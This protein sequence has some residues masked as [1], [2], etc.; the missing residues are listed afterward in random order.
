MKLSEV[1]VFLTTVFHGCKLVVILVNEM[2]TSRGCSDPSRLS[3][4]SDSPENENALL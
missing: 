3:S 2:P 4:E 1:S